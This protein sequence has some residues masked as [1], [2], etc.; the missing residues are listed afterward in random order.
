LKEVGYWMGLQH[1]FHAG[2]KEVNGNDQVLDTPPQ[3]L[4]EWPSSAEQVFHKRQLLGLGL[5]TINFP[6]CMV[7][8]SS[9]TAAGPEERSLEQHK[10]ERQKGKFVWG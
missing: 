8:I 3:K 4:Q 5:T 2:H 6:A 9:P 10:E 1:T 7:G